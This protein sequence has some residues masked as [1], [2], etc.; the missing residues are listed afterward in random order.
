[1]R[2]SLVQLM[3]LTL[4][5][6]TAAVAAEPRVTAP[7]SGTVVMVDGKLSPDEWRGATNVKVP[8]VANL[9]FKQAA[10]FVYLAVEYTRAESGIVDLYLSPGDGHIYDLHAS[11]KLG[12]RELSGGKWPEWTWWNNQDWVANVSRPDSWEKRTFLPT[13]VREYQILRTRFPASTWRLR[14]ELTPM[15]AQN[16]TL[17]VT[18]FPAHTTDT[19]TAD[20]LLLD[21]K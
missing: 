1:M 6:S 10:G 15:T 9:Y 2:F 3:A 4:W 16:Q 13:K 8:G 19:S 7:H 11:A 12:E 17:P 18:V 5:M 14:F 20:W 21:L